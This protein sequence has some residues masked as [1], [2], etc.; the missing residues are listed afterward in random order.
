MDSAHFS[1]MLKECKIIGKCFTSTD[2]DLLFSKVKARDAPNISLASLQD[3]VLPY[4][5]VI[6]EDA[7]EYVEVV[8][9]KAAPVSSGIQP[10]NSRLRY[11]K[12][13]CIGAVT[14]SVKARDARKISYLEFREKAIPE[15]AAK[16]KKSPADI[17]AMISNA[18]PMSNGTKAD[19]VRFHD[20]KS[21]YTGAAKQGGPTNVDRNPGSLA[22]VVDRRQ[23]TVDNRGTTAKQL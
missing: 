9:A 3:R 2:A 20:D 13:S 22:G 23:E 8:L 17:E 1:K 15:I 4:I 11:G 16:M 10:E 12:G 19:A 21:T 18:A 7:P 14:P 5:S 6:I